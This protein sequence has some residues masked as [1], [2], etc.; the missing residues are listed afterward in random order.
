MKKI[1]I[2]DE[3]KKEKKELV[4]DSYKGETPQNLSETAD[5]SAEQIPL[6]ENVWGND[7]TI[8]DKL[9]E[10]QL[11]NRRFYVRVRYF[12]RIECDEVFDSLDSEPVRLTHPIS[13]FISDISMGGIGII[14]DYEI[15]TGK[16]FSIQLVLDGIPYKIK[17]QVIYCIP[18]DDKF[19]AGLKIVEREKKFI[20]H[21]KI[22][23]AR[24]SLNSAYGESANAKTGH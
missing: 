12:Q 8:V 11:A 17:C 18:N 15:A 14:C 5:Q 13:F 4:H 16:I 20:T 9:D 24:I 1:I 3:R 10:T 23:V 19:R 21:L 6:D 22:F 7:Y 2:G